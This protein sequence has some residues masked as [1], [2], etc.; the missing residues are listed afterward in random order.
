ML[1]RDVVTLSTSARPLGARVGSGAIF[2][3]P[4]LALLVSA[5]I[6]MMD[7]HVVWIKV[8][9]TSPLVIRSVVGAIEG[10]DK[11]I[12]TQ[13]SHDLPHDE[14]VEKSHNLRF[15][16]FVPDF[17]RSNRPRANCLTME[18]NR[19]T[20]AEGCFSPKAPDLAPLSSLHSTFGSSLPPIDGIA[21]TP[22]SSQSI[23]GHEKFRSYIPFDIF[24]KQGQPGRK[25]ERCVTRGL[26]LLENTYFNEG[27]AEWIAFGRRKRAALL[28]AHAV[29][30]SGNNLL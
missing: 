26:E 28:C 13:P 23:S 8:H 15:A 7:V 27:L 9:F 18:I 17:S 1:A 10:D 11:V 25:L 21:I 20:R 22:L 14:G 30:V 24:P 12:F 3:A 16:E 4:P 29:C 19:I 5:V 6:E 2:L